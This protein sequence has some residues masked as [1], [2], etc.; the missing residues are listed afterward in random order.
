MLEGKVRYKTVILPTLALFFLSPAVGELISGSAPPSEFFNP[1][2]FLIITSLYGSGAVL[3]REL[4]RRWGKGYDSLL[5]LGAAYGIIE[6]G[7]TAKSFFD[8]A[9]PDLGVLGIFGRWL[10]VNW[11]WAEMLTIYHAVYSITI[12]AVLVELAFPSLSRDR[13]VRNRVL[14]GFTAL[15]ISVVLFGYFVLTPYRPKFLLCA[16]SLLMVILFIFTAWKLPSDFG[17][18]GF[19]QLR[20]PRYFLAAGFLGTLGFFL[21]FWALPF[22]LPSPVIVMLFGVLLVLGFAFF[23]QRYDWGEESDLH[24]LALISGGLLFFILLAPLQELSK[25]RVDAPKGMGFVGLA[26]LIGLILLGWYMKRRN[27]TR[28]SIENIG[29]EKVS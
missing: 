16:S 27:Q 21:T 26:F 5:L 14:A 13:W 18:H 19:I 1:I 24:R 9:W 8:P 23:V 29:Q 28:P 2:V 12:P 15:L 4:A 7:L 3:M 10:G 25:T 17:K 11:V 20:R 6:E 22:L